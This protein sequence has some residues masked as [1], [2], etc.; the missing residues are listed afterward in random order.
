M[1]QIVDLQTDAAF[2]TSNVALISIALDTL[3]Q[4]QRAVQEYGVSVP[5]LADTD[6]RVS[7]SYDVLKWAAAT[8]EPGHTFVLVG[9]DGAIRWIRDY[10]AA[11]NGGSMYVPPA[12]LNQQ[13]AQA[14]R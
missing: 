13:I 10:G 8:G 14:L 9:Q 2:K 7:Q 3:P 4:Q 1:E 12:E 5:M 6:K 11:E